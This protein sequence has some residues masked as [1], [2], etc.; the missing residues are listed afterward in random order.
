MI[1][2]A[3]ILKIDPK[4]VDPMLAVARDE[5]QHA[6]QT[7]TDPPPDDEGGGMGDGR[8]P[9]RGPRREEAPVGGKDS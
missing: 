3:M 2:R 5:H 7:V 9:R 6:Y 8:G 4:L 1:L